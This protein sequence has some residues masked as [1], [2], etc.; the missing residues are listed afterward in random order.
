MTPEQFK[1]VMQ[2][3]ARLVKENA[4]LKKMLLAAE[5]DRDDLRVRI[6]TLGMRF[7]E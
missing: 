2:A 3:L 7:D 6:E 4:A 5:V 1:A